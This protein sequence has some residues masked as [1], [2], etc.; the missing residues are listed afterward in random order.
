M[1]LT[2]ALPSFCVHVGDFIV[3][4]GARE[5]AVGDCLDL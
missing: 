1:L 2:G 4:A 3:G 5:I